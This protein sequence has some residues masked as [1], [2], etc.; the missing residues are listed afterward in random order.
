MVTHDEIY[1]P[2]TGWL[3]H[4]DGD[5]V[6]MFLN[7]GW[8]EYKEQ[9]LLWLYLRP[10]DVMIDCG[11]HFGLFSIIAARVMGNEGMVLAIEPNPDSIPI[12]EENFKSNGVSCARVIE[13]AASSAERT[14]VF[15]VG[16]TGKAAYG[17]TS[18]DIEHDSKVDVKA[19]TLDSLCKAERLERVDF[20]KIDVEGSELATLEGAS[21]SIAKGIFP[22]IMIEFNEL[23]L[24]RVGAS[25]NDLLNALESKGYTV[26]RFDEQ[27]LQLVSQSFDGPVWYDNYF[28]AA[29]VEAVNERL[30]IC[31]P[32]HKRIAREV[33]ARGHDCHLQ[34]KQLTDA[35]R[36]EEQIRQQLDWAHWKIHTLQHHLKSI[37]TSRYLNI[38][39]KARIVKKPEWVDEFLRRLEQ[40]DRETDDSQA[41]H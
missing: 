32:Q 4:L 18:A 5:D 17:S 1:I 33:L 12:L 8:F 20:L 41:A 30:R 9:A 22:L 3:R 35:A 6:A 31:T 27:A 7:Q 21:E 11:A 26:C 37:L 38:G 15:Y 10:G 39:W 2:H 24:R 23:N 40:Q 19:I 16:K 29:D 14:A 36:R 13:A 28:A 34:Y 25:T